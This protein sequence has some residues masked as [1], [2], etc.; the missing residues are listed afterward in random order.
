MT[1]A[2]GVL[3]AETE[4]HHFSISTGVTSVSMMVIIV[5]GLYSVI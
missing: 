2:T 1:D 3:Y 5:N 4:I